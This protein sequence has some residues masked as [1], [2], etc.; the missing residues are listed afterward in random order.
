MVGICRLRSLIV[1]NNRISKIE[2]VSELLPNLENLCLMSNKITDLSEID[3]L[4][5]MSKLE[6]LVLTN[7]VIT[8]VAI[9]IMQITNYR[10]YVIQKIPSLRIL[11]FKKISR[12]ERVEAIK[13]FGPKEKEKEQPTK[14][15]KEISKEI[16]E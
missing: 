1:T 14:E 9:L 4:A 8:E 5:N 16:M 12:K 15:N 2:D 3:N 10:L 6:R 13:M 7:N 11:D